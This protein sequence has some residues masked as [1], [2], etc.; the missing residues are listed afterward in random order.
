M[1]VRDWLPATRTDS[2]ERQLRAY[3]ITTAVYAFVAAIG[4]WVVATHTTMSILDLLL[5]GFAMVVPP[6]VSLGYLI[7]H[8][9]TTEQ[10]AYWGMLSGYAGGLVWFAL[11]KLALA[12]EFAAPEGSSAVRQ[13][14]AYCLTVNGEG[15]DPSYV[16]FFVPMAV[17][18]VVS[19]ITA[20]VTEDEGRDDFY[21]KLSGEKRVDAELM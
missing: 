4:A 15:L 18:P 13:A 16:T 14:L 19:A 7:Y 11:V 3:R 9:R 8:R 6:A 5:F 10:G 17:V 2:S 21:A 1:L 20:S 12:T